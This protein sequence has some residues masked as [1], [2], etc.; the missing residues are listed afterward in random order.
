MQ[1]SLFV[2]FCISTWVSTAPIKTLQA[3]KKKKK[4][5]KDLK[6]FGVRNH[7]HHHHGSLPL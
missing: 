5:L 2:G 3:R 1:N 7:H 6:D 4:R